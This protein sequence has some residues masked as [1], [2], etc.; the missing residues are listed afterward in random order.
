MVSD[1]IA[2]GRS[3]E[4]LFA[5]KMSSCTCLSPVHVVSTTHHR[6]LTSGEVVR[7]VFVIHVDHPFVAY[8]VA[9]AIH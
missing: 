7:L 9:R 1:C 4:I 5:G 8:I 3:H 6:V 2:A